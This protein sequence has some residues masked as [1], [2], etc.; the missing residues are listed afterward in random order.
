MMIAERLLDCQVGDR[1]TVSR[2]RLE[3]GLC[4]RLQALGIVPGC[5]VRVLFKKRSRT[6]V[7]RCQSARYALGAGAAK[8]IFGGKV[9]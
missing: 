7:I 9:V 2:I 5:Q 4:H 1:F 6:M 3:E 8:G